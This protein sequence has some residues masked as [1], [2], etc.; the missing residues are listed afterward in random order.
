MEGALYMDILF[1]NIHE[2]LHRVMVLLMG[3]LAVFSLTGCDPTDPKKP[4]NF[5]GS[6]WVCEEAKAC[7]AVI[8]Q[9]N[10]GYSYG[11][12]Q[13][14]AGVVPITIIYDIAAQTD[15]G[16]GRVRLSGLPSL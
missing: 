9:E 14:D 10:Y 7:V 11:E 15:S 3:V 5:P 12:V 4:Y 1:N 16:N 6:I 8:D 2:R 13:T